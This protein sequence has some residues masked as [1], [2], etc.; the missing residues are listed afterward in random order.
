MKRALLI[1]ALMASTISTA[2]ADPATLAIAINHNG[3]LGRSWGP[4]AAATNDALRFCRKMAPKGSRPCE[5]VM[6][7]NTEG[8]AAI[9]E[10]SGGDFVWTWNASTRQAAIDGAYA[11]CRKIGS[12]RCKVVDTF[13]VGD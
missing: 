11:Q 8:W 6:V 10:A 4:Y 12:N 5:L 13:H 1:A 2:F 7:D 3:Q 9:A